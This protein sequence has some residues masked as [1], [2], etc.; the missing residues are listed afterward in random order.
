M[1]CPGLDEA[2]NKKAAKSSHDQM[3]KESKNNL[4]CATRIMVNPDKTNL[5]RILFL[6]TRDEWSAYN[7][8]RRTMKGPESTMAW[9]A[10][11]SN[12]A[13]LE[14]SKSMLQRRSEV[15]ELWRAGFQVS[16]GNTDM[17]GSGPGRTAYEDSLARTL[18]TLMMR[19]LRHRCGSMMWHS[20]YY[21]G[22][23][24][25]LLD[26]STAERTMRDFKVDVRAWHAARQHRCV[27]E[28]KKMYDN[29]PFQNP[30]MMWCIAFAQTVDFKTNGL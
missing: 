16:F 14:T 6:G 10:A 8:Q 21:P 28:V 1:E 3:R 5:G 18:G 15:V 24:A 27:P 19:V 13:W 11:Q 20:S 17:A 12:F 23:L 22:K 4:H 9:Y 29:S 30:F 25:G 26:P 7:E 2:V